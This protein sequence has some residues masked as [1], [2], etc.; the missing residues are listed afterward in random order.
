MRGPTSKSTSRGSEGQRAKGRLYSPSAEQAHVGTAFCGKRRIRDPRRRNFGRRVA[1]HGPG[2]RAGT[3]RADVVAVTTRKAVDCRGA[4]SGVGGTAATKVR[5]DAQRG[6][7][8]GRCSV[9]R[10]RFPV[11]TE[12]WT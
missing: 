3:G 7:H 10:F 1:E 6:D 12:T 11:W 5:D 4:R 2:D 9:D 8:R